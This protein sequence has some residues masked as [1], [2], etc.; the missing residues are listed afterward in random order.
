MTAVIGSIGSVT[1]IFPARSLGTQPQ[2]AG[3]LKVHHDGS[4]RASSTEEVTAHHVTAPFCCP[5][6]GR[7]GFSRDEKVVSKWKKRHGHS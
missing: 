4:R 1:A 3:A 5:D 7:K 2:E 6:N